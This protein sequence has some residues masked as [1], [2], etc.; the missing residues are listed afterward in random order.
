MLGVEVEL[1]K[2]H[3][4]NFFPGKSSQSKLAIKRKIILWPSVFARVECTPN[5]RV[6]VARKSM[7]YASSAPG[8]KHAPMRLLVGKCVT[9]TFFLTSSYFI[10]LEKVQK[11]EEKQQTTNGRKGI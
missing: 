10:A 3:L 4:Y 9:N 8:A 6:S 5:N 11:E 2:C 7:R 1:L